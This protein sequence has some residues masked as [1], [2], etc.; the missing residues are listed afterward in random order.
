MHKVINLIYLGLFLSGTLVSQDLDYYLPQAINY[1]PEIPTP[2]SVI[3]HNVGDWHVSHDKLVRYMETIAEASERISIQTYGFTYEGR[4]LKL[5]AVTSPE[6][7]ENLEAIRKQHLQLS[8]PSNSG[9]LDLSQMPV[10]VWMGYSVHGNEASGTNASMLVAYYLAA[11]QGSEIEALLKN[12]V[13]LIDPSINPDGMNR[14]ASWVNSHRSKNLDGN[15]VSLEHNEAWPRGRTNHYWFDLNRDWLPVQHPESQGRIEK[16]HEW[17]PNVLTDH[18]EMGAHRT[19]F[20]NQG[21]PL[22]ITR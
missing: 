3:G 8:D 7:Q 14:F 12:A 2:E 9:N 20:S 10:V 21:C 22:V 5:L 18:H 17:K 1:N 11:A 6:N 15:P 13:I 19:F 4:E 16:Y